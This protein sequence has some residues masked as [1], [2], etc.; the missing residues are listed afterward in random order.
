MPNT[1][2]VE[3]NPSLATL[4]KNRSVA[5][6]NSVDLSWHLLQDPAFADLQNA[7]CCTTEETVRFRQLVVNCVMATDIADKELK[8]LRNKRWEKAFS[9]NEQTDTES[10]KV[11]I[12]R[13]ATIVIEHLLQ[14]VSNMVLYSDIASVCY[15]FLVD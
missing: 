3:E 15:V 4:Y 1:R 10:E 14:A 2:L 5:E 11:S 7:I 12:D 8:T 6:Q 13:K 9:H